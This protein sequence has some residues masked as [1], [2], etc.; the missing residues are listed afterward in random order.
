MKSSN[1]FKGGPINERKK[2]TD[3]ERKIVCPNH[4]GFNST[5]PFKPPGARPQKGEVGESDRF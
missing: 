5:T 1:E 3:E 4:G 2:T